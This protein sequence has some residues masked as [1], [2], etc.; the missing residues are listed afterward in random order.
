MQVKFTVPGSPQGKSRP[1]FSYQSGHAYTP[2]KTA[3]Y[4]N[5]V[6]LVYGQIHNSMV[7]DKGI[8]LKM[9]IRAYYAIPK[10]ASKKK[11]ASMLSGEIRPNKKPDLDNIIKVIAD[12]LNE[13]AYYDDSQIA[14]L[15]CEKYYSDIPRVEVEIKSIL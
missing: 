2:D 4:E 12:S 11:L 14:E 1:R 5:L 9:D 3:A 15:M 10:S 6:K 7:F 8:S 13:I